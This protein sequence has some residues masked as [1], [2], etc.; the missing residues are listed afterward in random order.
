MNLQG[1]D[2]DRSYLVP[3]NDAISLVYTVEMDPSAPAGTYMNSAFAD[4]GGESTSM[5]STSVEVCANSLPMAMCQNITVELTGPTV[6]ITVD[7]IDN[8]SI[9]GCNGVLSIDQDIFDCDDVGMNTVTLTVTDE[10]NN[11]STCTAT[12]TVNEPPI[13]SCNVVGPSAV[14]P[15][16]ESVYSITFDGNCQNPSYEWTVTGDA[17]ISGSTTN[18]TVTVIAN[19]VCDSDYTVSVEVGCEDCAMN[20]E[21]IECSTQAVVGVNVTAAVI[22][23]C[24]VTRTIE[25]CSTD[26]ITDP[27]FVPGEVWTLSSIAEME[28][29]PNSGDVGVTSGGSTG[30]MNGLVAGGIHISSSVPTTAGEPFEVPATIKYR[31]TRGSVSEFSKSKKDKTLLDK[32]KEEGS[33]TSTGS[34]KVMTDS[35]DYMPGSVAQFFTEGFDRGEAVQF[36]VL[37][38]DGVPNTGNGH[39]PW[40]VVDGSRNDLDGKVDGK[41]WTTWFVDPDDSFNSL[42]ELKATGQ[43]S[44]DIAT[45]IFAD[46]TPIPSGVAATYYPVPGVDNDSLVIEVDWIWHNSNTKKVTTAAVFA[47]L[48]GVNGLPTMTDNPATWQGGTMTE[49]FLGQLAGTFS[50]IKGRAYSSVY[51]DQTDGGIGAT[52]PGNAATTPD[53]IARVL[54]PYGLQKQ[55]CDLPDPNSGSFTMVYYNLSSA[56][57]SLCVITY[58]VHLDVEP[59]SCDPLDPAAA[60]KD[61]TGNHSPRSAEPDRNEDNSVETGFDNMT[62]SCTDPESQILF[63]DL[64]LSKS[65]DDNA[66]DVSDNV[67]FTL[68]VT[69]EDADDTSTGFT[70]EDVLPAGLSYVSDTGAGSSDY[71]DGTNTWTYSTTLAPGASVSIMITAS[72]DAPGGYINYAQIKTANEPDPDSTPGNNST[73][74]DD[75]DQVVLSTPIVCDVVVEYKDVITSTACPI[76]VTRTWRVTDACGNVATCDQIINV[77][78]TTDPV[79][80]TC[81]VERNIPGDNTGVIT[82]PVYSETPAASSEAEFEDGVNMGDA[83]DNCGITTV[84]Y[85]DISMG[86]CPIVVTRTW[87]VS[88]ACGN[89]ASCQQTINI[90]GDSTPPTITQCPVTRN[91]EGCGPDVITGP[92]FSAVSAAS[93]EAEFED[94]VNMGDASDA[95]GITSVTY[96]DAVSS[97][98]CPIVVT[99]TWTVS[100]AC[101]NTNT[102]EQTINITDTT[103]PSIACPP[104]VTIECDESTDPSNTG[105]AIGTDNCANAPWINE[106][107]YDNTGADVGEFVEIAGAAGID[108]TGYSIVLYNGATGLVYNTLALGLT[109]DDEGDGFGAV[110][111]FPGSG[112]QNDLDGL[113]LVDP[114]GNVLEFLSYEGTFTAND[115]PAIGILSTDVGVD[116]DPAPAVGSSL[117]RTGDG[118]SASDFTWVGPLVNSSGVLNAGQTITTAVSFADVST[119][120]A[121]AIPGTCDDFQYTITRTWTA[122]DDCGNDI[123]CIQTITV[124]DTTAPTWDVDACTNIG[125]TTVTADASCEA[126]MPDLRAAA[127]AELTENCDVLTVDDIIQDPAPGDPLTPNNDG[128]GPAGP[129]A[130]T[131]DVTFNVADACGNAATELSC[132]AAVKVEDTTAPTWDVDA[133]TNIGMT[134]VTADASCEAVMPDLRAAALAELTENCDVL[135]VA[136]IIQDPAPGDP[137]TP[138]VGFDG[139]GPAGPVV[140]TVDVTFN[141]TDCNDNAALELSCTAAVKV[142]DTTAPTWDVDAC[143]NIGMTTV[144]A[145]ANCEAVMPDLRAAALAELTENCDVLTVADIIQDPA[146]GDPL[147]PPVGFDGCGPAGPVV[148]TVDVTFNVT[149]CND[150]AALELSCTAAVKV[151]DT[152]APTWDVDACTNI[153]MTTVTADAN[154]EAVMPDLRA[155]ALAEL[156]ENCDVL[157]VADIIQD[158]APG[159]PLTPPVGFDGCGPAGP[160]VYT[161]DVTFNVTDCNDNAA[162]EL[163]CTAAVKVEDTTAPT[164]DVDAC[165]NI[166]MTTVTADASC[167]AVMPDLRAA[168]LAELTENCDVLTV[169]DIIQDPAP[170]DPLTPP[171]GFDGCGPAGPVVYTVDVTFNVTDCNDNAAVELSCTAA[172]KV[173]DTTA[174]TWDVDAC[175][176]IGMTTVTADANCEAV[177][178]DLR[179]AALAELTENCD[180]LTVADIIQDPAPGDPLT[181]PVGFDGCGPAGPVVYTVDVTFNVTDCNDNAAVELSCTA[182]VKVED[183]TAP[184]WDVDA[185]TNIGMTTVTA[186][187]SCEAVMPDLRAAALAELTENCDVLTVADIIQDPAPGDPLTPPVGFDGCGPAGPV[188]YTVDVTFNV[189][190]CNDNAALELSCT[191]AVKVEDTTAPTWD[192]DACTNIGMTTVTADASCEAVMPDLRAAALAE[193]TENCDVLTVADIIQ[194]PAPGD[195]LTPPVGFDGCGPAGP[196]VY[197]VDV[198]FNVTDCN[199]NAALELS[200]TAAVKVEDTTAPTWDVD[201]CTNIGMTTVTADANCEAVM[202]DLRAA[203]LAELTENC[204]VLTVADIIQDPAPGDPL[205]P[206]VGFDGCGPAGPVVYTVDVTFNVTDCN[207]NAALELSCTAAVKVED[208]T[209]PTWD[210]DACTNIGMTTVTADASCEAVMPDL[211]AAALAEL[212]EN[213]DVLTVADIIQ[214]PAPGDPL[215]PPVGFDGCGPAGP[216]VYTVD[217]TFN[218]TDCNDNAA[219]ELSCT[220]AVKVEDTTAPTWDVDACT[221]IGMTTVT[222][223][224][225]CEAVMPDLRAAALAELTENCDV[226]TVADIIQD[227]APGDPLTPPVGFDG[228]G[229]A[230]PVV[231][232]VDVTFNVTDCND[233]AALE[234]SCTAAVK[235]EDTTAPTWDVDACTNIGM[236]TVTADANCEAVMPDLRAAAL[237]ELTENCDVLTVADII[238]DPAPG[239]PLTPPVG[240]DGCGP[241]GPVVYTVD[242]T[243]NVTDCNDNAALELSCTAAVKVEDTTAPTWDVDACTNIGMTTVTADANCEAVMPDLRAAALAE[244]TENCDVLT[245]ADIIQDPAPGDPLTPPVGFDGCGPAGPVVY[246]VD[247]TFNVTDCNDNAALELSCTAAVK[248]EDTTAPTWDVDA[249]TN[250]GMTTVTADASCEAVMPDLRAAALAELTEN[251]DVLTVDDIIQDPAPGSTLTSIGFDGCMYSVDVTFDVTDC[252]DN[253]AITLTCSALVKI[254]DTTPPDVTNCENMD[255]TQECDFDQLTALCDAWNAENI[256]ALELCAMDDCDQDLTGQVTSNYDLGNLSDECGNTG[257]LLVTYTITG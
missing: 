87:T 236:T 115:G 194:D 197:T 102:C 133:C 132:T 143:T 122:T 83:S 208:T 96:I 244:L 98:T 134:T 124:D 33:T 193:L 128:C 188:V 185:C 146:P 157:T 178:P 7:D 90:G 177:M 169:A 158:P 206:P 212:T 130:Y 112:I 12:V 63:V 125:M 66:P 184:T 165:T 79:I 78:D 69:N 166:G 257:S 199:D 93:S 256:T 57:H 47:D 59:P 246:T 231:Y 220:A 155:A 41:I 238:Q 113:A 17:S 20:E 239:D 150:N 74:E 233:N 119:Q 232:T 152:T 214:D 173:E 28:N 81:P 195:P 179:A 118:D 67:V 101:G 171:V 176:N 249:C 10:C 95:S 92:V 37:H 31:D 14:C 3:A 111:I 6:S 151:E 198:T 53:H 72:V 210:V 180:V 215:T 237:A 120:D 58:D 73:T 167:E 2:P 62:V 221:N 100:D 153:G 85:V 32:A 121:D 255:A 70:V 9:L 127:L 224:A 54:F 109:I 16:A 227:P 97:G 142:E 159:D 114:F 222:A 163:S 45:K 190:D 250:I 138:P 94:G 202:P 44:G 22:N 29:P 205:T 248:V 104:D 228:C 201:A 123:D 168:A 25:G 211:R 229:P 21:I 49:E 160:V 170:G 207:D 110:S 135:T 1:D 19:D 126:V 234:L 26:V 30:V 144:T 200:C 218:V 136:D 80:T 91:I 34:G 46:D 38:I 219:L 18:A 226:L 40:T 154:C 116:E 68:T 216:V 88:D 89:T 174:P 241:A 137:L 164:W 209:A 8:G 182:A 11:T 86:T 213:C 108:L 84:T 252:N 107:H 145:D 204:D 76:V 147:T 240:F 245:V 172:V 156:T 223:D 196:V 82:G 60:V 139:C 175:T 189:T 27:P 161:V 117:Q 65:V 106:F 24:P 131:V 4:I 141:V 251:C 51:S 254:V 50:T 77:D 203:A 191:A 181:P 129:V 36:H 43:R 225:N 183:T 105:T 149:D 242:V 103:D 48:D 243:F 217:V 42:F 5:V 99:R 140:Y 56:P 230:G 55:S 247:V 187:A 148:Y 186:D 71:D 75:D 162:L 192:V 39:D 35:D 52:M 253:A 61:A 13:G 23:T 64:A 235:V 15:L